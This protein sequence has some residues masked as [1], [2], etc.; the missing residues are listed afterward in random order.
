MSEL[1]DYFREEAEE[2]AAAGRGAARDDKDQRSDV[3]TARLLDMVVG[4]QRY[5][6]ENMRKEGDA[7]QELKK[8]LERVEKRV[9]EFMSAFPNGDANGHL[10]D[11][12]ERIKS[13]KK[14]EEFIEKMKFTISALLV[15]AGAVW[16]GIVLWKAFILGPHS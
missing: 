12:E 9:E 6:M 3:L 7:V 16:A 11:H 13:A 2:V 14:H 15:T 1:P 5:V 10:R 4:L 8:S